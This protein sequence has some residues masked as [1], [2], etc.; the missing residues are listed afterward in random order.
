M[1]CNRCKK[2]VPEG[3]ERVRYGQVL[4]TDCSMRC[5]R[6][7]KS[8]SEGEEKEFYGQVI[9]ADCYRYLHTPFRLCNPFLNRGYNSAVY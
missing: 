6:C 3:K 2:L 5:N 4:C 1:R 9:C 8:I 7:K